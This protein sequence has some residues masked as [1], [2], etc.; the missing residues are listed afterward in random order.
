VV[1]KAILV[2][3][4]ISYIP[5][6]EKIQLSKVRISLGSQVKGRTGIEEFEDE[7]RSCCRWKLKASHFNICR[8]LVGKHKEAGLLLDRP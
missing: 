8:G 1:E 2:D 3:T 4:K 7:A 5:Y 6:S